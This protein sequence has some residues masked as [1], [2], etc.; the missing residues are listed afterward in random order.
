MEDISKARNLLEEK[1]KSVSFEDDVYT[2]VFEKVMGLILEVEKE[3]GTIDD[4][5]DDVR[6]YDDVR[7]DMMD[8]LYERIGN[9]LKK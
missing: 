7:H 2:L 6:W 5:E 3:L 8:I 4:E 9:W 1:V